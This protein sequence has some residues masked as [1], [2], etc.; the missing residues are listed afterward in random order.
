MYNNVIMSNDRYMSDSVLS[1][2]S[3]ILVHCEIKKI[4][5]LRSQL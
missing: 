4:I 2:N 5:D 1:P 3:V